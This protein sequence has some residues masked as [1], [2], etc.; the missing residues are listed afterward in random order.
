VKELFL[1]P[2]IIFFIVCLVG[3]I[4]AVP[5][6]TRSAL[7]HSQAKGKAKQILELG[8]IDKSKEF[9]WVSETLAKM[10][11]DLEAADLWKRLQELKEKS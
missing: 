9:E 1:N 7:R 6:I 4:I 5:F 3:I 8:R 10:S 2:I 11:K